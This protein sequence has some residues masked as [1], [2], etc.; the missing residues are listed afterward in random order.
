VTA[1]PRS[2]VRVTGWLRVEADSWPLFS[3]HLAGR[4]QGR[5]GN[6]LPHPGP[7]RCHYRVCSDAVGRNDELRGKCAE[8]RGIV[9]HIPACVTFDF[10]CCRIRSSS[11]SS[12]L[13]RGRQT[14]RPTWRFSSLAFVTYSCAALIAAPR[15][16]TRRI[17]THHAAMNSTSTVPLCCEFCQPRET[18]S[19]LANVAYQSRT[20]RSMPA[21]GSSTC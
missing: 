16:L 17:P 6:L 18:S 21:G 7:R 1:L 10:W 9:A 4:S 2:S 20:T 14:S 13:S 3:L 19:P 8:S 15:T 5:G 12:V 11:I